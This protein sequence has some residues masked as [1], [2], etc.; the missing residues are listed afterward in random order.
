[1]PSASATPEP[2]VLHAKFAAYLGWS[3][4]FL[5]HLVSGLAERHPTAVLTGRRENAD[6]FPLND[7]LC[8]S[9]KWLVHPSSTGLVASHLERS[10]RPNLMHAHFGWSGIRVLLLRRLLRVPLV[11][12]FG[13]RDAGAE[14]SEGPQAELYR[15]LLRQSAHLI[16]VS[17]PLRD[18]LVEQ[19][20]A[21][22]RVSVIRRGTDTE[23]FRYVDR[24]GRDEGDPFRLLMVGRLVPKKGHRLA[25]EALRFLRDQ[26]ID[27]RLRIVGQGRLKAELQREV[28]H[29]K[30][31]RFVEFVSPTDVDGVVEHMGWADALVQ[32]SWTPPDGD[33]EG[34]PNVV[35]EAASTGLPVLGSRHG[36][37]PETI[38]HEETGLLVPEGDVGELQQ[39]LLR[40]ATRPDE[41]LR[42]GEAAAAW[43][44]E[45]WSARSQLDRHGELYTELLENPP[46]IEEL[47]DDLPQL[48]ERVLSLEVRDQ[49]DHRTLR[50]VTA[51]WESVMKARPEG[52]EHGVTGAPPVEVVKALVHEA[53]EGP[54][55][56]ETA[57]RTVKTL[58]GPAL[59]PLIAMRRRWHYKRVREVQVTMEVDIWKMQ[60]EVLQS[61]RPWM[62]WDE[63]YSD[64]LRILIDEDEGSVRL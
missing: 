53:E 46:E 11:T 58:L 39:A 60:R 40:L 37:I 32:C 48:L 41:R 12:T 15:M 4:P 29:A 38:R 55:W 19:G 42:L 24:A 13:G 35:V 8:V 14:L 36:G 6:R 3:Q 47:P 50:V 43:M 54:A 30:L 25:F 33:C 31:A 22:E 63:R 7:Y 16:C 49:Y 51:L 62:V 56:R 64:L 5:H 9:R 26:R 57:K 27:A 17:G 23:R 20:A 34:I 44:R 2:R 21:P 10:F 1:M 45:E 18:S 52:D 59:P 61:D 28:S